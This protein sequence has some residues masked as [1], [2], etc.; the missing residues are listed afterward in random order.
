MK[1]KKTS[2]W[3]VLLTTALIFFQCGSKTAPDY[4]FG[5]WTTPDEKYADRFMEIERTTITFGIGEGKSN[6]YPIIRV[7]IEKTPSD[8]GILHTIYYRNE[9]GLK[10]TFAFYYDPANRG[11]IR[12]K[13]RDHIVWKKEKK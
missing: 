2:I 10:T 6:T 13:Y 4:L 7:K 11:Q 9:E 3:F 8:K 1:F 12:L 5:V